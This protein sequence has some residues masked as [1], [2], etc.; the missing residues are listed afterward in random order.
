MPR[1]VATNVLAQIAFDR[2]QFEQ[3]VSLYRTLAG[4]HLDGRDTYFLGLSEQNTRN[5]EKAIE[6]LK[7]SIAIEPSQVAAHAALHAI[8]SSTGR[9]AEAEIHKQAAQQNQVLQQK[10]AGQEK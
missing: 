10:H 1:I 3:A 2:N 6:A 5:T 9:N 7:R 4:Y 8:Y